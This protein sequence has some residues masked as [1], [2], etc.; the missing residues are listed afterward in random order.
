MGLNNLY[1]VLDLNF[2]V[3]NII[4]KKKA[5]EQRD[6]VPHINEKIRIQDI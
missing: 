5:L 4:K 1:E 2:I 3:V 6:D